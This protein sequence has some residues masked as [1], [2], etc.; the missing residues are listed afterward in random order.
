M[1]MRTEPTER[2]TTRVPLSLA[3]QAQE[4][5]PGSDMSSV[6]RMALAA[7]I[8]ADPFQFA[9][10]LPTGRKPRSDDS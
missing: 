6:I 1:T 8:G 7:W 10:R 3:R 2:I 9:A 5:A 4:K